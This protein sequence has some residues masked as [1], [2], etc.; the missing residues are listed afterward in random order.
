MNRSCSYDLLGTD[1]R[2]ACILVRFNDLPT[3][4]CAVQKKEHVE[5]LISAPP[6]GIYYKDSEGCVS[7][8]CIE[9]RIQ[10]LRFNDQI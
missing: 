9:Q 6:R 5:Y 1:H 2:F 10:Q 7:I 8:F 3:S 4:V